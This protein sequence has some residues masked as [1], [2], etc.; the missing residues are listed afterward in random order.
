MEGS[1]KNLEAIEI[2]RI[3]F[4][5]LKRVLEIIPVGKSTWWAGVKAGLYPQSVK[6]GP[7]VTAWRNEDII[8]FV[9]RLA[10]T[11]D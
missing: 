7:G 5:R 3:G 1:G 9:E 2:P 11:N 4:M 8:N 10:A 6:L